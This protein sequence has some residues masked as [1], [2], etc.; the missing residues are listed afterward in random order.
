MAAVP[1]TAYVDIAGVDVGETR[2]GQCSFPTDRY[3]LIPVKEGPAPDAADLIEGAEL[4]GACGESSVAALLVWLGLGDS[5]L[6]VP[7]DEATVSAATPPLAC[8]HPSSSRLDININRQHESSNPP[9]PN[10][11][12]LN[13]SPQVC[14]PPAARE[15][16]RVGE[17]R[18]RTQYSSI[19]QGEPVRCAGSP[20]KDSAT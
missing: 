11:G 7:A 8:S 10:A 6:A 1:N 12:T 4:P 9:P 17:G 13:R 16:K 20:R 3:R 2:G 19:E 18:A 15:T 5:S 14:A